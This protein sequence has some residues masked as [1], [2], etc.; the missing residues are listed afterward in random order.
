MDNLHDKVKNYESMNVL[1]V[2]HALRRNNNLNNNKSV[3]LY[4]KKAL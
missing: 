2:C 1:G 4:F 3:Q